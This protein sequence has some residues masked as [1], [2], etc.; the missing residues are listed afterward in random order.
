MSD[1]S[2]LSLTTNQREP[3]IVYK[4]TSETHLPIRSQTR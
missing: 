3:L 2:Q 4:L 1:K